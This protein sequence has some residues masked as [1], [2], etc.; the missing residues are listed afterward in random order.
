MWHHNFGIGVSIWDRVLG[1]YRAADW[2]PERRLRD[3]GISEF[4]SI[5]WR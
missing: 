1:T 2:R 3:Y 4:V 5:R